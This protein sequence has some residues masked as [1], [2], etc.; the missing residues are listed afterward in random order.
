MSNQMDTFVVWPALRISGLGSTVWYP[1][2][3]PCRPP[4]RGGTPQNHFFLSVGFCLIGKEG[5]QITYAMNAQLYG[6]GGFQFLA[7]SVQLHLHCSTYSQ[8]SEL[9]VTSLS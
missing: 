8:S 6:T 2:H 5:V 7:N 9:T 4:H 1:C 3:V